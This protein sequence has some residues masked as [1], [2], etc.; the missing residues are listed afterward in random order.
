MG[1]AIMY[2][3][4]ICCHKPFSFNP[5]FVPSIRIN[6]EKEPICKECINKANPIRIEKGLEPIIIHPEAYK[7]CNE[8]IL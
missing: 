1:Y 2:G 3:T 4:C 6:K 7:A 5:N 8:D